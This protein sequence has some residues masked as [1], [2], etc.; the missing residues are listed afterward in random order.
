[1]K[2]CNEETEKKNCINTQS[3]K[4]FCKVSPINKR[5]RAQTLMTH[6]LICATIIGLL[7]NKWSFLLWLELSFCLR[8]DDDGPSKND[9]KFIF[10]EDSLFN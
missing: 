2:K 5:H 8:C 1:M 7:N 10:L 4:V 9:Y 3:S 6:D